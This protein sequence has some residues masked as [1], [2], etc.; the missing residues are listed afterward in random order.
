MGFGEGV[1]LMNGAAVSHVEA[2]MRLVVDGRSKAGLQK[3]DDSIRSAKE[4]RYR[5]V[6]PYHRYPDQQLSSF[7][8]NFF[9]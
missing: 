7:C 6:S 5:F 2:M 1:D 4:H 3:H 8:G 9:D